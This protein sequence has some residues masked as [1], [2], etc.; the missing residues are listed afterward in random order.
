MLSGWELQDAGLLLCR[1][2]YSDDLWLKLAH[3]TY[4]AN[5]TD[6]AYIPDADF[7]A[8]LLDAHALAMNGASHPS[9]Y[10]DLLHILTRRTDMSPSA[11][12]PSPNMTQQE[13][14]LWEQER[15]QRAS[16]GAL[17]HTLPE[18]LPVQGAMPALTASSY[19][20]CH[21][22]VFQFAMNIT[23]AAAK[24]LGMTPDNVDGETWDRRL[25]RMHVGNVLQPRLLS[26]Y[27]GSVQG[28]ILPGDVCETAKKYLTKSRP[29][30]PDVRGFVLNILEL[31]CDSDGE[32]FS[33]IA[34]EFAAAEDPAEKER[35]L[36]A[37]A[38]GDI[39]R[40]LPF[41]ESGKVSCL[42]GAVL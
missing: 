13:S 38:H 41:S 32:W 2:L 8:L 31:R 28:L 36:V 7:A 9:R 12:P 40:A 3:A 26:G 30:A 24:M 14:R 6:P 25:T 5:F 22:K 23:S 19:H 16:W 37:L 33:I 27:Q 15:H 35:L 17:V 4:G 11:T 42:P 10:L 1:V 29:L 34:N 39:R 18:L 20:D 21:E